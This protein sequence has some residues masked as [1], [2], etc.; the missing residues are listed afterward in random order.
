MLDKKAFE[1]VKKFEGFREKAY[2]CPA[3]VPTVGYGF[4]RVNNKP[5]ELMDRMDIVKA[6]GLLYL[7]LEKI[8][9]EIEKLVTVPL[10][11]K[12]LGALTSFVFNIGINGFKESTLRR[13]LNLRDYQ[14]VRTEL[15]R[16]DKVNGKPLL[17]LTNRRK[18]EVEL[19]FS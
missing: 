17:G 18:L 4:T 1:L 11:E 14:S 8:A 3:G 2:L 15:M 6:T 12:Q 19:F 9:R 10:N 7:E 13:K 5:V 16:W